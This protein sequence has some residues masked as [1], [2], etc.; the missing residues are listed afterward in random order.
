MQSK[1]IRW[2]EKKGRS[3]T[4]TQSDSFKA[5]HCLFG[6]FK[7]FLK[8]D[9]CQPGKD[10]FNEEVLGQTEQVRSPT[11]QL[12]GYATRRC[13][14]RF[15]CWLPRISRLSATQRRRLLLLAADPLNHITRSSRISLSTN[16]ASPS[17]KIFPIFVHNTKRDMLKRD[18]KDQKD[19]T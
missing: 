16:H 13:P 12:Y 14:L 9:S 15:S 1:E 2:T 5:K 10:R 19:L 17:R 4:H 6:P 8:R 11:L 7:R 3:H 18:L